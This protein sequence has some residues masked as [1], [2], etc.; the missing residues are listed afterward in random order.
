VNG[1]ARTYV[2]VIRYAS[3]SGG[4]ANLL[5]NGTPLS[6]VS[7]LP[8]TGGTQTWK[9]YVSPQF[10]L[11]TGSNTIRLLE[12]S[13]GVNYN[14]IA[15][16]PVGDGGG[17]STLLA[18]VHFAGNPNDG[19]NDMASGRGAGQWIYSTEVYANGNREPDD[20]SFQ[21][22]MTDWI[23]SYLK[24]LYQNRIMPI[25]R[26]DYVWG[27]TIPRLL[28]NDQIDTAAVSRYARTFRKFAQLADANGVPIRQ[29]VVAN[30]MNLK[31]EATG[32]T[33]GYIPEW[34][35]AYVYDAV[36]TEMNNL[37]PGYEVLVGGLSPGTFTVDP[38]H[39]PPTPDQ[40]YANL[41]T[42]ALVY[43]DNIVKEIKRRG[44]QSVAFAMH[45]YNDFDANQNYTTDFLWTIRKELEIIERSHTVIPY[46]QTQS[47]T[48]PGFVN[49][50][51]YITEWNRHTPQTSSQG[52]VWQETATSN[53][54]RTAITHIAR[55][56]RNRE[57][58]DNV[59]NTWKTY[60]NHD[61]RHNFHP[62]KGI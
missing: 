15:L 9:S 6:G 2:A 48:I 32:F 53:F 35:Y 38:V 10:T 50:P 61:V 3:A 46:N 58:W 57:V 37:G 60:D 30:E 31:G 36:R 62:I 12:K 14:Y 19:I 42:D 54:I 44:T 45:A 28:A 43:L 5:V 8:A 47:V 41:S 22:N 7:S 34:Y 18:G 17:G 24:P 51:V 55:F 23:N 33:N 59:S 56:N 13:S 39:T 52:R 4:G 27:E 29:Y 40:L 25:V 11:S 1:D 21:A 16:I 49:A 20:L 26:I